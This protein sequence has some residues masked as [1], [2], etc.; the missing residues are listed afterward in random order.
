MS[1]NNTLKCNMFYVL[2]WVK[3]S[4]PWFGPIRLIEQHIFVWAIDTSDP[5]SFNQGQ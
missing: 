4:I 2:V 5:I 3:R 1:L